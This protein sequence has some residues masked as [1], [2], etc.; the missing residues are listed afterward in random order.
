MLT[1][2]VGPPCA[3]KSTLVREKAEPGDVIVDFD[4]LALA[5][6]G[7]ASHDAE[8]SVRDAAFAARGAVIE[9][10]LAHPDVDGY[11]IHSRPKAD[12]VA[13]YEAAGDQVRWLLV[14]PGE[15]EC[16][17]RAVDDGRPDRTVAAIEDWYRNP[18]ALPQ[19]GAT[20]GKG[21]IMPQ[22]KVMT[23][24]L[25]IKA[26][27]PDDGL[28]EG[29]FEA[30]ASVFG[31]VD[32]YG[33][34]V[35]KGAFADTLAD[36]AASGAV[37]PLLYGHDMWD[38]NNNIGSVLSA[39]EDDHGLKVLGQFDLEGGN[40]PHVY[41]MVKGRRLRELSFAYDVVEDRKGEVDGQEVRE[42]LAVKL[43]EVSLVPIGANDQTEVLAVKASQDAAALAAV[44][45]GAKSGR[46]LS[47]KNEETLREARDSLKASISAIDSVLEAVASS[48]D[49][50]KANG[51]AS[52]KV[53]EPAKVKAED[54]ASGSSASDRAAR[55]RE[56]ALLGLG[57]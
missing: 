34:V 28:A 10:L 24:R 39:E 54:P 1:I 5:L 26:A 9:F 27:G 29:Q 15:D 22:T 20:E 17:R 40:G 36:W 2:V 38:P 12:D 47:A 49:P 45:A 43:Y 35:V 25:R 18:P 33:D 13:A 42:L 41:R 7:K 50:G 32:S 16:K 14:D 51:A 57:Q 44:V 19:T 4:A 52:D 6:G 11:V 55:I 8:P 21:G 53:E 30:Y 46:V 23:V 48:S 37:I 3:G 31:N 56:L